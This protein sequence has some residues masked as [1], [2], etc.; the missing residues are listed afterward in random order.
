MN[1]SDRILVAASSTIVRS[2]FAAT[3]LTIRANSAL[4]ERCAAQWEG[5]V[6][7]TYRYIPLHTHTV[8][9]K[10][11]YIPLHTM[12]GKRASRKQRMYLHYLRYFV[13]CRSRLSSGSHVL[14]LLTLLRDLPVEVE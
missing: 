5:N 10:Y 8:T 11:R 14:T 4:D 12:G 9:H 2:L 7:R 1:F 3:L 6:R 13:T